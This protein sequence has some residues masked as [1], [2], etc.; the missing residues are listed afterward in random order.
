MENKFA[1]VET[2]SYPVLAIRTVTA[3]GSLPQIIGQA[4][5]AIMAYLEELGEEPAEMPYTAYFNMDMEHLEVEMGFPV[6]K[7]L[8]GRGEI[9]AG[10][11]PA[12]KKATTIYKGPYQG[13]E[14]VYRDLTQW[15]QDNGYQPSGV[16]YE[17]YYNSP[18]EVPESELMTKI[19][20]LL[21]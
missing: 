6:G 10:E 9:Q 14:P 3:V 5:H 18:D 21:K 16:V 19:V 8:P 2:E 12:G 17:F 13:M 7:A 1:V 4:Y 20:F 15:I 11:I